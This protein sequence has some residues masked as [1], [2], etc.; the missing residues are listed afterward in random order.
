MSALLWGFALL[1]LANAAWM[2]VDPAHWYARLPAGVPD[3]GPLNVHF[4]RDIGCAFGTI[5]AALALA[6]WRPAWRAPLTLVAA[7]F[8]VAHALLHVHDTASGAVGAHH[9]RLDL[10]P[11]H[12]P[13]LVLG[14]LAWRFCRGE[15]RG[16][17]PA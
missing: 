4:V 9:W 8:A 17:S 14:V 1:A 16:P 13:A 12:L 2:L 3:F 6:A 7:I 5:G 15:R 11:V 10:V